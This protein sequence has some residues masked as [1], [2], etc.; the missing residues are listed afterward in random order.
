MTIS[1]PTPVP[2]VIIVALVQQ[3]V[4][5]VAGI[6]E[7]VVH[8]QDGVLIHPVVLQVVGKAVREHR[9]RPQVYA[10]VHRHLL[11]RLLLEVVKSER[12]LQE[13][14]TGA[15]VQ[16]AADADKIN[17]NLFFLILRAEEELFFLCFYLFPF[18]KFDFHTVF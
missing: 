10:E 18:Q 7:V 16:V 14:H 13:V 17:L 3:D 8:R 1:I 11:P 12:V 9:A 4:R 15:V 6:T 5:A 2:K